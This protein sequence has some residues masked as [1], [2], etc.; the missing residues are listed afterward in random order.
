MNKCQGKF[1]DGFILLHNND[2]TCSPQS[3]D[4][5][6]ATGWEELK[7]HVQS[8]NLLPCDFQTFGPLMKA[9]RDC[10]PWATRCLRQ[11]IRLPMVKFEMRKHILTISL[12]KAK[13]QCYRNF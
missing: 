7:H 8:P 10:I 12:T 4:Q 9:I 5:V 3:S 1:S 11:G 13:T 6:S 2:A